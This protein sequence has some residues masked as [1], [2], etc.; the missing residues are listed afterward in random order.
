MQEQENV[1]HLGK[2][3]IKLVSQEL[4]NSIDVD[5]LTRIDYS[6]L[7]GETITI[8]VAVQKFGLLMSTAE[9]EYE[10][11]KLQAKIWE[12]D[13]AKTTRKN[14]KSSE[15]KFTE[16]KLEEVV[17]S[18]P[19]YK[20]EQYKVIEAKK[21]LDFVK[22]IFFA[23]KDKSDKLN[24]LMKGINPEDYENEITEGIVNTYLIKINKKKYSN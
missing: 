17:F 21:N 2:K 20:A 5:E 1:I 14:W 12:A 15:E 8:P 13:F 23:I 11:I 10:K 9:Q 22:N 24:V 4:P 18:D 3:M 16:K 19:K 6:N 7:F